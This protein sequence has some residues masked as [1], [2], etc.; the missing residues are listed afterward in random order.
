MTIEQ[1]KEIYG[2]EP[3]PQELKQLKGYDP[4]KMREE[5]YNPTYQERAYLRK[6]FPGAYAPIDKRYLEESVSD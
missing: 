5:T 2:K 1:F 6:K 4:L 3:T